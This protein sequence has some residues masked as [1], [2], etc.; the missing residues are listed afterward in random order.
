MGLEFLRQ[1][2]IH[3]DMNFDPEMLIEKLQM[4]S[5]S[6]ISNEHKVLWFM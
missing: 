6:T 3:Y 2:R 5:L 1:I 4:L